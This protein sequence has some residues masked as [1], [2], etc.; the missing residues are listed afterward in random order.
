MDR[1][2]S[3]GL[4]AALGA[5]G[6]LEVPTAEH[7]ACPAPWRRGVR[8]AFADGFA[9]DELEG[10]PFQVAL[11]GDLAEVLGGDD[12]AVIDLGGSLRPHELEASADGVRIWTTLPPQADPSAAGLWI[13]AGAGSPAPDPTAIWEVSYRGV[14]HLD[15]DGG[16]DEFFDSTGYQHVA[17]PTAALTAAD[18]PL[19]RGQSFDGNAQLSVADQA[20]LT[21][22]EAL[23]VEAV[24]RPELIDSDQE[25]SAASHAVYRLA[26]T[27]D[28]DAALRGPLF[29]VV[30]GDSSLH[31]VRA[32]R[33][34]SMGHDVYLVG[35]FDASGLRLYVDGEQVASEEL[36]MA[37][38]SSSASDAA[39]GEN[40]LGVLDE[41]RLSRIARSPAYVAAQAAVVAGTLVEVDD[42]VVDCA[43]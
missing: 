41:V 25:R 30:L 10:M 38:L 6:C 2:T 34:L 31:T 15:Q 40:L 7:A 1:R 13:V 27:R 43:P 35:T 3:V 24:V 37:S 4:L 23:T 20:S 26:L 14:W 21:F 39:I 19:G 8:V 9:L 11:S 12:L 32:E 33:P 29:E 18:G 5:T 17:T 22:D 16:A 28:D 36:D 42:E